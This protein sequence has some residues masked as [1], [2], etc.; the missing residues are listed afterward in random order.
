MIELTRKQIHLIRS[1]IRQALGITSARRAPIVT[2]RA[3]PVGL[4]IQSFSDNIAVEHRIEGDFRPD[5]ITLPY[6]ALQACEG[7]RNDQVSIQEDGDTITVQW[8][9][10]GIRE[11][12][13]DRFRTL[14]NAHLQETLLPLDALDRSFPARVSSAARCH[15][16]ITR[17][18]DS[19][20]SRQV[21]RKASA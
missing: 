8:L 4:L 10:G 11:R 21:E 13:L 7:K 14:W 19:G 12:S 16:C 1:T 18:A 15:Q 3:T 9:D 6:E 5:V 20:T 17:S 2:F